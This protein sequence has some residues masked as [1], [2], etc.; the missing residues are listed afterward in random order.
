ML[1]RIAIAIGAVLLLLIVE[2]VASSIFVPHHACNPQT[3]SRER[4]DERCGLAESVTYR[5]IVSIV[6]WIDRRHDFVTAAATV[7]IAVFTG[8]IWFI[9]RSQLQH[10]HQ[11]ERAYIS[12]GGVPQMRVRNVQALT[13]DRGANVIESVRDFTGFFELHVNNH[14]KTP[15]ELLELAFGFCES[16]NIPPE[17]VYEKQYFH[18]WIAPGTTSRPI[19]RFAVPEHI[20]HP[21]VYG[22]F[23]YRD[24]FGNR[25]HSCGFIQTI[26]RSGATAP[27]QAPAAYTA[28][29]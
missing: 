27:I 10:S 1:A 8:T 19:W 26:D 14:G 17:P 28:F 3:E 9:N 12:G 15:G 13:L 2:D 23:F 25:V 11:I 4:A 16:A 24:I 6:D 29:D 20:A 7:V 22:R 5:V 18:D 21:V